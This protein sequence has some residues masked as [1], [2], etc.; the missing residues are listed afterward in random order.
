[1]PIPPDAPV[2]KIFGMSS[3]SLFGSL[4]V[5]MARRLWGGKRIKESHF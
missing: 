1:V 4:R 3:L 2:I 5:S